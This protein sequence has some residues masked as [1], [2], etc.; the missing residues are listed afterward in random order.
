[1]FAIPLSF[2][3]VV[4]GHIVMGEV[5]G[6]LSVI[7]LV[8]LS[9]IVVNDSLILVDFVN[10]AR[11]RG[12]SRW[13]S[14]LWGGKV[15]FRPIILTSLTTIVAVS[16]LAFKQTGQDAFLAPMAI[17]I[18]WGLLFGTVLIL[19]IVPSLCAI[20]DDIIRGFDT[21]KHQIRKKGHNQSF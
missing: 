15:R 14:I 2:I 13:R 3:G 21:V 5:F 19:L 6:L 16:T 4:I 9:G 11:I 18:V 1:M 10:K 8:A 12:W 17:S 7:G 20:S